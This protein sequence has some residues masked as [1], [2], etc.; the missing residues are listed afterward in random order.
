MFNRIRGLLAKFGIDVEVGATKIRRKLVELES[1]DVYPQSIQLMV[2][3]VRTQVD[4]LDQRLAE[5]ERQIARQ[6]QSDPAVARL[7][8]RPEIGSLTADAIVA[9]VG[10]ARQ[11]KNG[12]QFAASLGITPRQHGSSGK[13]HLVAITRRGDFYLRCLLA[14][15]H[16]ASFKQRC[17]CTKT[18]RIC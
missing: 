4:V 5:C 16:V 6:S 8:S 18:N 11:Y 10:D 14:R 9:M 17:G 1:D 13:T 2:Q 12:R 3:S 15:G 7:R